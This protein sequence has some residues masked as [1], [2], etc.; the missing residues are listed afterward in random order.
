MEKND[1]KTKIDDSQTLAEE[2]EKIHIKVALFSTQKIVEKIEEFGQKNNKKV[3][4]VLSYPGKTI[5]Q[6]I[7]KKTRFDQ[8]FIDYIKNKNLP[9]VDLM[10]IH[11]QDYKKYNLDIKEYINHYFIGHYN[12]TGNF[13]CASVSFKPESNIIKIWVGKT[14]RIVGMPT[15]SNREE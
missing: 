9:Y 14:T 7:E 10:E 12:P 8:S 3:L 5:A 2:A 6:Y 15:F 11:A 1:I 4:Y 13:F